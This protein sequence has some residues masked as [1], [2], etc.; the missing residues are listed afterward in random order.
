MK[1]LTSYSMTLQRITI[2]MQED[3][4]KKIRFLQADML[5][6]SDASVSLSKVID[7]VLRKGLK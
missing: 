4:H 6:K 2:T 7:S 3:M 1:S 5:E